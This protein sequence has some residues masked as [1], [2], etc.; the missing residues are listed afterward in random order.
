MSLCYVVL[1]YR[2]V[3]LARESVLNSEV[4]DALYYTG[5]SWSVLIIHGVLISVFQG[6]HI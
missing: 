5:T 4:R 6:V 2:N 3:D 1:Q